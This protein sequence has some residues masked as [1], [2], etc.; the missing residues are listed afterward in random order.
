[1]KQLGIEY[2]AVNALLELETHCNIR[3]IALK[4]IYL[5][6]ENVIKEYNKYNK[7]GVELIDTPGYRKSSF[8]I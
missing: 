8:G 7:P 1:M 3:E 6:A 5:Y 4:H 2:I